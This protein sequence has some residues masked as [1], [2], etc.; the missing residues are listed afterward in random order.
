MNH[1]VDPHDELGSLTSELVLK[2]RQ[3]LSDAELD[4]LTTNVGNLSDEEIDGLIPSFEQN[5]DAGEKRNELLYV[6][7]LA[8]RIHAKTLALKVMPQKARH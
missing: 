4:G 6:F 3:H 8:A 2:L 7:K 5:Q 1:E